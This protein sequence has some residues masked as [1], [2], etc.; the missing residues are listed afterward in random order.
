MRVGPLGGEMY[1]KEEL[2]LRVGNAKIRGEFDTDAA[3][4]GDQNTNGAG[5]F[6]RLDPAPAREEALSLLTQGIAQLLPALETRK[7]SVALPDT[8]EVIR[9]FNRDTEWLAT[10]VLGAVVFAALM[11]AVLAPKR[12]PSPV[13]STNKPIT[14]S[15]HPLP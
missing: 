14:P 6:Q 1:W 12:H 11:L 8:N 5:L 13:D 3:T 9:R 10:G 15:N 7:H 2:A 4:A